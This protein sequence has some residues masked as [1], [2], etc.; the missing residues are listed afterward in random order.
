[1]TS[2]S[3]YIVLGEKVAEIRNKIKELREFTRENSMS[4]VDIHFGDLQD[5]EYE[6]DYWR[7]SALSC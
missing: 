3:N 6:V 4:S 5:S 2:A 7:S 1:M